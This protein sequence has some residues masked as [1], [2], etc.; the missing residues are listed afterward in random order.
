LK[1][2]FSKNRHDSLSSLPLARS[3]PPCR[4]PLDPIS[5]P[6]FTC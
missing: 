1:G 2:Q 5:V 6:F 3:E 4:P